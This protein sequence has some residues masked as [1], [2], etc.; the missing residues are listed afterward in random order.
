VFGPVADLSGLWTGVTPDGAFYQ[1]DSERPNCSYEADIELR[2]EQDGD[3]LSGTI[4]LT[5]RDYIGPMRT[6]WVPC[7]AVGTVTTQV[8]TGTRTATQAT[9]T[10][11]DG[12]TLLSGTCEND[13]ISGDLIVNSSSGLRGN[14]RVIR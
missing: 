13:R 11:E 12:I 9:F 14:W 8:L 3:N 6:S 7:T 10:L 1:D 2:L 4:T 5:I